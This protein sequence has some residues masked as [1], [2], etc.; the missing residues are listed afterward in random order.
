MVHGPLTR[1]ELVGPREL[2]LPG[3]APLH[4][5]PSEGESGKKEASPGLAPV[6]TP[7]FISFLFWVL[8][9]AV[10]PILSYSRVFHVDSNQLKPWQCVYFPL[11]NGS[12]KPSFSL[13]LNFGVSLS[14]SLPPSP[15]LSPTLSFHVPIFIVKHVQLPVSVEESR[16]P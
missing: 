11:T 7:C 14:L 8:F 9:S 12:E 2:A 10:S 3:V 4:G 13:V 16:Q 5:E 6:P 1:W 15:F